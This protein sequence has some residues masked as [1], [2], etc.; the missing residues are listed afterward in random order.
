MN[1]DSLEVYLREKEPEKREKGYAWHTAV[2]LQAVDGLKPSEYLLETARRNIEGEISLEQVGRLIHDYYRER[3]AGVGDERR[4][5]ADKVSVRIAQLLSEQSFSFTPTQY[6]SIHERLFKGIYSHAGKKRDYNIT[7]SEWI[8]NGD[9]VLYGGAAELRATLEYDLNCE[10]SFSYKGLEMEQVI[11]HLAHF[12]SRLWQI[13]VFGEGNT[14]TTAVF[15][16]KYLRTLG[17]DVQNDI[18]AEHARYFRNA[19]VRANYNNIK[20]NV[21]ETTEYLERF[22]RNLLLDE[23]NVLRNREMH[24]SG[25]WTDLVVREKDL[26]YVCD[27]TRVRRNEVYR[28]VRNWMHRNAREVELCLWK[29][30]FEKGEPLSVAEALLAYQNEDGGFGHALEAD[31][32]NPGSTPVCTCTALKYMKMAGFYDYNHPVYEGIMDFIRSGKYRNEQG[33]MFNVPENNDWPRAPWWTYSEEENQKEFAGLN[34]TLNG[35]ILRAFPVSDPLYTGALETAHALLARLDSDIP[36][37]DSELEGFM[38]LLQAIRQ[39]GIHGFDADRLIQKIEAKFRAAVC[40]DPARFGEYVKRPSYLVTHLDSPMYV[41]L[42]DAVEAE[43]DW[44]LEN[45]GADG[46]WPITWKWFGMDQYDREFAISENW[47]KG[48]VAI[49]KIMFL[50][51]FGRV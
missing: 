42:Q 15:F 10:K 25:A 22:L 16:I 14:R 26:E 36:L 3:P 46:V 8:L 29:V 27:D 51:A 11:K 47:W 24:I 17:F 5:E 12:V 40:T 2:G 28:E 1:K 43:L 7:K 44:T 49:E 39:R 6:L 4:E 48:M 50:R 30:L 38:D 13:H 45:R 41:E 34:A 31:N 9:T 23:H 21:H 32:W 18:F 33:W 35:F 37:G 19:L 20:K